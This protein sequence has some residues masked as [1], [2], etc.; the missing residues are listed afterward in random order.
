MDL[1]KQAKVADVLGPDFAAR[2]RV[3]G[4][5]H[6]SAYS[7]SDSVVFEKTPDGGG[8]VNIGA[9]D[10]SHGDTNSSPA[11]RNS[12][13]KLTPSSSMQKLRASIMRSSVRLVQKLTSP[14]GGL[15]SESSPAGSMKRAS[16]L[17]VLATNNN[18]ARKS[19][20]DVSS[21]PHGRTNSSDNVREDF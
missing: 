20:G 8:D 18:N 9:P 2:G 19:F 13:A 21:S 16:S 17:S 12:T 6:S 7:S 15:A 4:R 3:A 10:W 1:A 5:E 11:D 14:H